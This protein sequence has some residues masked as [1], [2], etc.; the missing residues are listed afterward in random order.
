LYYADKIKKQNKKWRKSFTKN[1]IAINTT[2]QFILSHRVFK[3][4]K[5][6]SKDVILLIKKNKKI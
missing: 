5:H 4:P 2:N 6:D 3:G 1:Q